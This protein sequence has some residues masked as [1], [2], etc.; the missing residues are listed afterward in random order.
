MTETQPLDTVE[1]ITEAE[2]LQ[3]EVLALRQHQGHLGGAVQALH[4]GAFFFNACL[5]AC[6]DLVKGVTN[7]GKEEDDEGFIDDEMIKELIQLKIE[8]MQEAQA[9]VQRQREA[10]IAELQKRV[11]PEGREALESLKV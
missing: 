4:E 9:E 11:T 6:I 1:D 8:E 2:K 10:Q 3:R 5:M 7:Q